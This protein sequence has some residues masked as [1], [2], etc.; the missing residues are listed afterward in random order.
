[1]NHSFRKKKMLEGRKNP[2]QHKPPM[3]MARCLQFCFLQVRNTVLIW[4]SGWGFCTGK[5]PDAVVKHV[6]CHFFSRQRKKTT[7][8]SVA[9]Q[10]GARKQK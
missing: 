1:M 7:L 4:F 3:N 2:V 5:N 9:S 8:F 10:T 6:N